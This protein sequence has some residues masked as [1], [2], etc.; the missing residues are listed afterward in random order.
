MVKFTQK[1]YLVGRELSSDEAGFEKFNIDEV[2]HTVVNC[3]LGHKPT[4]S[5]YKNGVYRARFPI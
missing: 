2:I 1:T 5:T 4:N 3:P